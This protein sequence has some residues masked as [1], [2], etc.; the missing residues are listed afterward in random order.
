MAETGTATVRV[1]PV[2]TGPSVEQRFPTSVSA[3]PPTDDMRNESSTVRQATVDLA[4]LIE[5]VVPDGRWKSLA[6][7]SLEESLMWANKAIFNEPRP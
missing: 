3:P 5:A 4:E 1:R 7:T 6:L 2:F